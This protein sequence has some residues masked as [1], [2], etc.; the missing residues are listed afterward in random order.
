MARDY[1]YRAS[2]KKKRRSIPPW[3]WILFGC[4]LGILIMSVAW[5]NLEKSSDEIVEWIGAKPDREP[6]T[7]EI[8]QIQK[9][10]LAHKPRFEFYEKLSRQEILVPDD[11]I[12]LRKNR[13]RLK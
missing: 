10:P 5:L 2:T 6:Q 3:I 4:L 13:F 12:E 9:K 7:I 1:K 11:Q 8:E